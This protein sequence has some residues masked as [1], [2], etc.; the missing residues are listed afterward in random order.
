MKSVNGHGRFWGAVG[1]VCVA[2]LTAGFWV[3]TAIGTVREDVAVLTERVDNA[4]RIVE[5]GMGDR[6]R[7]SDWAANER[8]INAEIALIKTRLNTLED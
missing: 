7:D 1:S 5:E 6:F 3:I 4:S 2:I 8:W